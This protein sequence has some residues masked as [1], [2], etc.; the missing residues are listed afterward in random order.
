MLLFLTEDFVGGETEFLVHPID[1]AL[2]ADSI[3]AAKKVGMR[4]PVG[5]ALCFPHGEHPLH[6]LHSSTPIADGV[7][8][9][10]HE[11]GDGVL[12]TRDRM[13]TMQYYGRLVSNGKSFDNSYR[14]GRGLSFRVKRDA[15]IEGWHDAV[16]HLPVGSK[17][18]LFIPSEM[19]YGAQG[20]PPDIPP[21]AELYFYVTV[22]ELFY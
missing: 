18:S 19:G 13:V 12:P 21:G 16:T 7:K 20:S 4:T 5:G 14:S 6:C 1:S 2:P 11:L 8:Y 22:D 10:I 15:I 3:S 17:A 9:I